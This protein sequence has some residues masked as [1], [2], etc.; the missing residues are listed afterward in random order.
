MDDHS[1]QI[2]VLLVGLLITIIQAFALSVV[3]NIK[4]QMADI[5][6]SLSNSE[7]KL[8]GH[9]ENHDKEFIANLNTFH[10]RS[11]DG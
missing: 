6:N 7:L 8:S 2:F 3:S 11:S 10:R 4:K 9:I 5:K 1:F